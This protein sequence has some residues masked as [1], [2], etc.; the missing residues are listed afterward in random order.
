MYRSQ[1]AS[2]IVI[3]FYANVCRQGPSI[4]NPCK[5]RAENR[6][7]CNLQATVVSGVFCSKCLKYSWP[8]LFLQLKV[9]HTIID[10]DASYITRTSVWFCD[11]IIFQRKGCRCIITKYCHTIWCFTF[12]QWVF[13]HVWS[14]NQKWGSRLYRVCGVI[15]LLIALIRQHSS[16]CQ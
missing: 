15:V 11:Q 13:K 2:S 7:V 10:N 5:F 8:I 4:T 14:I 1:C 16:P 12:I 6:C 9:Q 3:A